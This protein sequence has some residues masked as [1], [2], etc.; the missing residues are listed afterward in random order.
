MI[1]TSTGV[2]NELLPD[3]ARAQRIQV[4]GVPVDSITMQDALS[5]IESFIHSRLPH[6]V[7]ALNA[8]KMWRMEA[9]QHLREIVKNAALIL[10][11]KVL[12]AASR[13]CGTPLRAYIG[14]DRLTKLLLPI[15]AAKQY[16]VF[17]LG[18]RPEVLEALVRNVKRLYPQIQI[19]GTHD[20]FFSAM[21]AD[22]VAQI[23][24]NSR[25]ELLFVGM[26]TPRQ[27]Y[28]MGEYAP[29]LGVPVIV[30][31]GGT[32]DVLAGYKRD[33]PEWIR[34]VGAEWVY[35]LVE[36]PSGKAIRYLRALPWFL[37]AV[38]THGILP[39]IGFGKAR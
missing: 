18:S 27:E 26:G 16:R 28:W 31:V 7:V 29:R 15:A 33:C 20:G 34:A 36:D 22:S 3:P 39:R 23:I 14:N 30:G 13:I 8:P 6:V 25:S 12:Y 5:T 17:F 38:F 19:S 24:R 35:R 9:D 4:L 2:A 32:L 1:T 10:P 21:E 11:E 37:K